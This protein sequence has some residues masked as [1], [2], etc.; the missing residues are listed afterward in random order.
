MGSRDHQTSGNE[1]ENFIKYHEKIWK[2]FDNKLY[3]KNLIT[4]LN[5][6]AFPF[7]IYS[8]TFYK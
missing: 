2:L 8:S 7:V 5:I 4:K 3:H 1:R 6:W